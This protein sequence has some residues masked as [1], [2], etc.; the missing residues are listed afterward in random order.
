MKKRKKAFPEHCTYNLN[1][2]VPDFLQVSFNFSK[3]LLTGQKKQGTFVTFHSMSTELK[4][5]LFQ[6]ISMF[7]GSTNVSGATI[8]IWPSVADSDLRKPKGLKK[9]TNEEL[10]VLKSWKLLSVELKAGA[11]DAPQITGTV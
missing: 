8:L 10:F 11:F 9:E 1:V 5:W 2:L 4:V 6:P 7:S 3:V